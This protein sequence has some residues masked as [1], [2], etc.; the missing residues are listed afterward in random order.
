MNNRSLEMKKTLIL[1]RM[2]LSSGSCQMR[3]SLLH[4]GLDDEKYND[5]DCH[6]DLIPT[7]ARIEKMNEHGSVELRREPLRNQE[8]VKGVI[9]DQKS[10]RAETDRKKEAKRENQKEWGREKKSKRQRQDKT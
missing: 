9:M 10:K 6:R 3:N 5:K 2:E 8:S 4:L 7:L 1:K